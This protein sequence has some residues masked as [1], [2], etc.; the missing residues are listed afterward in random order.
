MHIGL[1]AAVAEV[2]ETSTFDPTVTL[3]SAALPQS[4]V[5]RA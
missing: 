2:I 4:P 3:V 1:V 5:T